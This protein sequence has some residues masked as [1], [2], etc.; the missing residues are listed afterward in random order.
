[1]TQKKDYRMSIAVYIGLYTLIVHY[2]AIRLV[3]TYHMNTAE[4][5]L[6]GFRVDGLILLVRGNIG[7]DEHLGKTRLTVEVAAREQERIAVQIV[8]HIAMLQAAAKFLK[9]K[10]VLTI[11]GIKGVLIICDTVA[12]F[13]AVLIHDTTGLAAAG[14]AEYVGYFEITPAVFKLGITVH[15]ADTL[16]FFNITVGRSDSIN[17]LFIG[18]AAFDKLHN[19][20]SVTALTLLLNRHFAAFLKGI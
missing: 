12:I 11:I 10:H 20:I 3:L 5:R 14:L 19:D 1:M 4:E 17:D 8:E 2:T 16:H 15:G 7:D 18:S 6:T 9:D 13:V